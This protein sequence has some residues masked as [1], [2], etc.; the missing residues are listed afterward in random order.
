ML[1]NKSKEILKLSDVKGLPPKLQK[2]LLVTSSPKRHGPVEHFTDQSRH[3]FYETFTY[4]NLIDNSVS[5]DFAREY[6]SK[7]LSQDPVQEFY[8][9]QINDPKTPEIVR[10][11]GLANPT[12]YSIVSYVVRNWGLF[13]GYDLIS[14]FREM[15]RRNQFQIDFY[16]QILED[17]GNLFGYYDFKVYHLNPLVMKEINAGLGEE[18]LMY[19]LCPKNLPENYVLKQEY[20]G[21]MQAITIIFLRLWSNDDIITSQ[22]FDKNTS[23]NDYN[24]ILKLSE[25]FFQLC[26]T[27][28]NL[29][30]LNT[31]RQ[32]ITYYAPTVYQIWENIQTLVGLE[33]VSDPKKTD[34]FDWSNGQSGMNDIHGL[35][36]TPPFRESFLF[37]M[38]Y[39]FLYQNF[40]YALLLIQAHYQTSDGDRM[41]EFM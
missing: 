1:Q 39:D 11:L 3:Y 36:Y 8:I 41:A 30:Q 12:I 24:E 14:V 26:N 16:N 9:E 20:I 6:M 38:D 31:T 35:L 19:F 34:R 40:P 33:W 2:E 7:R 28:E 21:N 25:Q 10:H 18:E 5:Y 23:F 27:G 32:L 15:A 13:K 37:M 22:E 17:V 29:T 4:E